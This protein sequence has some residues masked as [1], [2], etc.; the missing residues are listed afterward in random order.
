[1]T[2]LIYCRSY[3]SLGVFC[4]ATSV[5]FSATGCKPHDMG[6]PTAEKTAE[7]VDPS[8]VQA[9]RSCWPELEHNGFSLE[10]IK[11]NLAD[12]LRFRSTFPAYAA[13]SETS[14]RALVTKPLTAAPPPDTTVLQNARTPVLTRGQAANGTG[15]KAAIVQST[16]GT[17]PPD[18]LCSI[19]AGTPVGFK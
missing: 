3:A 17:A 18:A 1:V 11:H 10:G 7:F 19:H 6:V 8:W 14:I 2:Q 4:V 12:P 9:T 15:P 5:L 13:Q 16:N